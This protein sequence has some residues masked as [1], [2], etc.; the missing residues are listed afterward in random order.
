MDCCNQFSKPFTT[1]DVIERFSQTY[2]Q[3]WN[4][5]QIQFGKGGKGCGRY[6]TPNVY[7]GQMLRRLSKRGKI[8]FL[9]F[10]DAPEWWGNPVIATY[11][12]ETS[13]EKDT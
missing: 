12:N 2:Q 5:L 11:R 9:S 4:S 7:I 3:D 8:Q 10:A 1:A 13:T 6:Y